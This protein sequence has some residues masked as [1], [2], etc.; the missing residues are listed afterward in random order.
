LQGD[1]L[2][3]IMFRF[4]D[5]VCMAYTIRSILLLLL[6]AVPAQAADKPHSVLDPD[7]VITFALENDL[8]AGRDDGYT[9][10]VR[11]SYVSPE[12][13][14]PQWIETMAGL[15]PFYPARGHTRW[16]L[17]LGQSMFAPQDLTRKTPDPAD[18]P[19]A[20][21]LY[22]TVG[23]IADGG[24]SLDNLQLTVGM[25]GPASGAAESQDL[26]HKIVNATNPE[27]WGSQLH[28]E[29][30]VIVSYEH[31]WRN[32][33]ELSPFGL[34][35]DF[36]P[37]VGGS[38]CNIY[39]HAAVSAMFRLGYDLPSDYGPPVIRPNLPGSDFF[40]PRRTFGW[41]FFGGVEGRAVARNIFLDG[42]TFRD[43]PSVGKE[44]LVGGVQAGVALTA[45]NMRL[46]YTHVL[47]T[48]EFSGQ[49]DNDQF[50]ALTLSI[51]Y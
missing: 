16:T 48:R 27:G 8:F 12:A 47:R 10:G 9:N 40:T 33:V 17:A 21:W 38:V 32:M 4:I 42:N 35:M 1:V 18:R 11:A 46:A 24:D 7:S 43:S 39:T 20:G 14:I 19:Y 3:L 45:G 15:V 44:W 37:S 25:V 36:T 31:K 26:V 41:Y 2:A 49:Q 50:G 34:G 13:N 30:G 5:G 51:R 29:P 22:G 6:L 28:N 23:L